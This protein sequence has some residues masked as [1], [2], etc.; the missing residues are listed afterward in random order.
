MVGEVRINY[1]GLGYLWQSKIMVAE[2]YRYN[3]LY[4]MA[5]LWPASQQAAAYGLSTVKYIVYIIC[6]LLPQNGP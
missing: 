6:A 1:G 4:S 3:I 2:S 5:S